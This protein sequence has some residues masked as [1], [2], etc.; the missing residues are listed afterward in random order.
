M[1]GC[2][3][4]AGFELRGHLGQSFGGDE[5]AG[6]DAEQREIHGRA[7][8]VVGVD[9][10]QAERGGVFDVIECGEGVCFFGLD[11]RAG[12]GGI[13]LGAVLKGDDVGV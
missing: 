4:A 1:R 11:D 5:G 2:A 6:L 12:E 3:L 13:G 10:C 8:L 9:D 7:V